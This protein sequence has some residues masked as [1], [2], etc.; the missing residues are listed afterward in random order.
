MATRI[1][2]AC[3][4]RGLIVEL[5]GRNA[6]MIRFLLPLIINAEQ[7]DAVASRVEEAIKTAKSTKENAYA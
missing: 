7:V 3:F 2:Q 4:K 1:Q 6:S 5:G